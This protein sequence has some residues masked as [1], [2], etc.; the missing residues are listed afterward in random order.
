VQFSLKNQI[1]IEIPNYAYTGKQLQPTNSMQ[2]D[3]IVQ[4]YVI[5]PYAVWSLAISLKL[6]RTRFCAAVHDAAVNAA[7][8]I[9]SR[10]HAR[11]SHQQNSE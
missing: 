5:Q 1:S 7:A 9:D 11:L 6:A 2:V 8:V 3:Q 4:C 10:N